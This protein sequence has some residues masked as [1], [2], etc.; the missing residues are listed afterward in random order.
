MASNPDHASHKSVVR[1][2]VS[3]FSFAATRGGKGV[4]PLAGNQTDERRR[5]QEDYEY[6]CRH[7]APRETLDRLYIVLLEKQAIE[8]AATGRSDRPRKLH[9]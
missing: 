3:S 5:A 6:A 4:R 7:K 2:R 8:N 9:W 1:E